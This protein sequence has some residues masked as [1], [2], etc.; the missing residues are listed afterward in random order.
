MTAM[1]LQTYLRAGNDP[2]TLTTRYGIAVKPHARYSYLLMFKYDQINSP[3]AEPI[4][5]ECRGVILDSSSDWAIVSRP[6]DKFFNH[7][8]PLAAPIDWSTARVQEKLDGSLISLYWHFGEWQIASSGTPDASG[9]AGTS[10]Q[11][12]RQLF[13]E[14]MA[15]HGYEL[16]PV[17]FAHCTF[18][19]EL[20]TRWNRIVV[21]H[22]E[23]RVVLLAVRETESGVEIPVEAFKSDP[24][25]PVVRSFPLQSFDDMAATFSTMNPLEQEGYVVVDAQSNRVKVKHPG[26]VALH[27]M[28]SSTGPKAILDIIRKGETTELLTHFPEWTEEFNAIQAKYDALVSKVD[29][30]YEAHKGI[31]SQKEFAIAVN[32]RTELPAAMFYKRKG[33]GTTKDFL[34]AWHVKH[35]MDKLGLREVPPGEA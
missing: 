34:A 23:P 5:R 14:V 25:P 29:A 32:A 35:L 24:M 7:G 17:R 27:H 2:A 30:D 15:R 16:P 21:Q 12:F 19:Y 33:A 8:D 20:M 18:M 22:P 26:Y 3:F 10:A 11:T 9:H 28:I 31:E 1:L 13:L 6:F 4:V